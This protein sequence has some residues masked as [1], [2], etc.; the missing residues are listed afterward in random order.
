MDSGI[1]LGSSTENIEALTGQIIDGGYGLDFTYNHHESLALSS[2][3]QTLYETVTKISGQSNCLAINLN[4]FDD[5]HMLNLIFAIFLSNKGIFTRG[6]FSHIK[7]NLKK[8]LKLR[9]QDKL[10]DNEVSKIKFMM[11][12]EVVLI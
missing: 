3:H 2:K 12:D 8:I 5:S 10:F 1:T 4:D 11:N 6:D 7:N 9:C